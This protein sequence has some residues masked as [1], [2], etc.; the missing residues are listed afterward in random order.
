MDFVPDSLAFPLEYSCIFQQVSWSYSFHIA[1]PHS[2]SPS[3][4]SWWNLRLL[5]F[6]WLLSWYRFH[7]HIQHK[8]IMCWYGVWPKYPGCFQLRLPSSGPH[9]KT[10]Q[11]FPFQRMFVV[12]CLH[13]SQGET[14]IHFVFL[15]HLSCSRLSRSKADPPIWLD[16]RQ[17][18]KE[19]LF[20]EGRGCSLKSWGWSCKRRTGWMQNSNQWWGEVDG[21]I[22]TDYCLKFKRQNPSTTYLILRSRILCFT[23]R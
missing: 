11:Y 16:K 6:F 12:T 15:G 21:L 8:G 19:M 13:C 10:H 2:F 3:K 5:S 23:F 14:T 9:L 4:A 20:L 1:Q 22:W 7:H 18:T 17:N